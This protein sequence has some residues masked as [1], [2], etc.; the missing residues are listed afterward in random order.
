MRIIIGVVTAILMLFPVSLSGQTIMTNYSGTSI[1]TGPPLDWGTVN[2]VGGELLEWPPFTQ[3]PCT[4][5]TRRI[6]VRG[7]VQEYAMV[8]TDPRMLGRELVTSNVNADGWTP[9]GPGSGTIWG[10]VSI[11]VAE[12][13]VETG[14]VW[15]GVWRGT[16]TVTETTAVSVM[17]AD[18][19]G[20][21]GRIEGLSA[22][23]DI[24]IDFA[25]GS[26]E[27]AG[28]IIEPGG[29]RRNRPTAR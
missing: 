25:V 24:V 26:V 10:T 5:D 8:T 7:L 22:H 12:E 14:E 2:C 17:R 1:P 6:H 16:R 11:Y 29:A 28:V 3:P 9:F 23:Y 13:G 27:I 19:H 18:V 21:G 4:P 20:S 15:N